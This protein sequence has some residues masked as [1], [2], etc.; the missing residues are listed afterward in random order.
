MDAFLKAL[1]ELYEQLLSDSGLEKPSKRS[2]GGKVK[3]ELLEVTKEFKLICSHKARIGKLTVC[4]DG[5]SELVCLDC[6]FRDARAAETLG[7]WGHEVS[8]T[9]GM[10]E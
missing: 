5:T 1:D 8:E 7:L 2:K 10:K 4:V 3:F 9:G 6:A